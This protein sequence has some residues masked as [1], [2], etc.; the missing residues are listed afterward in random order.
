MSWLGVALL[1]VLGLLA[2][3]RVRSAW[4]AWCATLAVF[5]RGGLRQLPLIECNE[6]GRPSVAP[7]AEL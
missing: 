2:V 3:R 7:G 5:Q 1:V 4:R 6:S